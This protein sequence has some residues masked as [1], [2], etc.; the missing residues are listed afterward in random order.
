MAGWLGIPALLEALR[1]VLTLARAYSRMLSR[2]HWRSMWGG[3]KGGVR[4]DWD[5]STGVSSQRTSPGICCPISD[6]PRQL[7][8]S[9]SS[10]W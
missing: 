9:V 5:E 7:K 6:A 10:L 2:M 8:R 3:G 4:L 1:G